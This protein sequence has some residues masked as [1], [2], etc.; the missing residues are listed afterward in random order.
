M[1]VLTRRPNQSLVITDPKTG[2]Q[3]EVVVVEVRGD[4]VRIG[5]IA[6]A[7]VTVDRAEVA[8]RKSEERN[9]VP[10]RQ[11][12]RRERVRDERQQAV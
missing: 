12:A 9:A 2:D 7:H 10:V 5:T 3:I 6:P 8:Q 11:E 4:Q 1:L